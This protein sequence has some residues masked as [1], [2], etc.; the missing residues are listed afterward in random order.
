MPN[1]RKL[2]IEIEKTEEK[3]KKLKWRNF[4]RFGLL[5]AS[6]SEIYQNIKNTETLE[7]FTVED[8][9]SSEILQRKICKYYRI[10]K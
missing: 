3:G 4:L 8:Q 1:W 9:V 10:R 2:K 7:P 5:F 6:L